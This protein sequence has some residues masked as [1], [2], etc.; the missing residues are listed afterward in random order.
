ML[1]RA[2]QP[3]S[4]P[5]GKKP[6]E[7]FPGLQRKASCSVP[8]LKNRC[9]RSL[10]AAADSLVVKCMLAARLIEMYCLA[11]AERFCLLLDDDF[12]AEGAIRKLEV[13]IEITRHDSVISNL[14]KKCKQEETCLTGQK[15]D[16]SRAKARGIKKRLG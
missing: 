1:G 16:K 9:R 15:K 13:H 12:T 6:R 2:Q 10:E 4:L 14:R 3:A 7:P 8:L 5:G 11:P